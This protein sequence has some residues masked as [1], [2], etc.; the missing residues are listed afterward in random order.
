MY[1]YSHIDIHTQA[2]ASIQTPITHMHAHLGKTIAVGIKGHLAELTS[3][4]NLNK[5][6]S[7]LPYKYLYVTLSPFSTFTTDGSLIQTFITG[8][9]AENK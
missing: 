6:V 9:S 5:Y 3:D 8:Q 4:S 1:I 2:H 7:K